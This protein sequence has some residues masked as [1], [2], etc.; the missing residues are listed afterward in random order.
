MNG[1]AG[2]TSRSPSIRTTAVRPSASPPSAIS[3]H[4]GAGRRPGQR[5]PN[6]VRQP[7]A[8]AGPLG[9]ARSGGAAGDPGR[10]RE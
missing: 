2:S 4:C 9:A 8:A 10:L 5:A 6:R 1:I 3:A 7:R